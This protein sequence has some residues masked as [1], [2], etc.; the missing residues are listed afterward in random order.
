MGNPAAVDAPA[1]A[2][3]QAQGEDQGGWSFACPDWIERLKAGRSLVPELP[4]DKAAADRAVSIFDKLRLPDVPGQPAMREAAG[5]WFR[6]I[7]RAGFGSLDVESGVRLV[8]EIFCLV[9]KKNSKTTNGAALMIT[10]MLMNQRPRAE[11]LLVGPTQEVADI[12]FQQ[13][14]GMI[15]ADPEGYLQKRFHPQEH[16][17]TITDRRT[18]SK[19]KIKTFDMRVMTGTK[20]VIVLVDELHIMSA[21]HFATRVIGQIRGGF[22]SNPESLLIFITTQSDQPPAGVFKA[23][24]QYA[25]AIRDGRIK[26]GRML[27]VLYEFP[28][29]MQADSGKPWQDPAMWPMVLPNLG[30]SITLDRLVAEAEGAREKGDEEWQRW[31]SQHLNV[32]IGMAI[33]GWRGGDYWP[34][35]ADDS[36]TLE[37]L[38][39]RS[40]VVTVGID[41][42]GLDDLFGL[43][44]LGRCKTTRD[45]LLWTRAWAQDDV[46]KLRKDIAERLTDFA[47]DG[48]LVL[49]KQPTEDVEQVAD[50]V[51][52]IHATGLL[53]EKYGVGLD[54][55]GVSATLDA[56][57]E[58]GIETEANGG[59][60]CAVYQGY[61]LSGAVWGMERKLKDGTFWHGGQAMM[62]WCVGNAK[63][64]QKGNA[65]LITKQVAG[66][67]KIDPL[68]AAFNAFQLMS[69]GPTARGQRVSPWEDPEY[70][71]AVA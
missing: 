20:P 30:R 40:E 37:A 6:D 12:A 56:L 14:S 44:V 69:R 43:A 22:I 57:T 24:L 26:G 45:W 46:L 49:C 71:L 36:L 27:P 42:G 19:L 4:L 35:A 18:K 60:V 1:P 39:E 25:R 8:P 67:A 28:E 11:F 31:A 70:R 63:A 66:K 23:E 9:P 61:K 68:M 38:L 13:A 29:P 48:D 2:L 53:P 5:D 41:G 21:S 64:E 50:I 16:L 51:Q 65:V 32:Q 15:E 10:A 7:V 58:R 3:R 62:N 55:V 34:A 54:P 47:R 52:R 17:K 33:G 59:P